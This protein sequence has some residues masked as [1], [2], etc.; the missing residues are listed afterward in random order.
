MPFLSVNGITVPVLLNT[1]GTETLDVGEAGNSYAGNVG[2][3]REA[4][5]RRT[6]VTLKHSHFETAKAF[7]DLIQGLGHHWSFDTDGYGSAGIGVADSDGFS[8]GGT[9]GNLLVRSREYDNASWTKVASSI[10]ANAARGPDGDTVADK[11]VEST[12]NNIHSV[13]QDVTGMDSRLA[14]NISFRVKPAERTRL[15][16]MLFD[17]AGGAGN[18]LQAAFNLTTGEITNLN[19]GAA[20]GATGTITELDDGWYRCSLAGIP[21]PGGAAGTSLSA[22]LRLGNASGANTYV[23]DGTSGMYLG[24]SQLTVGTELKPYVTTTSLAVAADLPAPKHGAARAEIEFYSTWE[25]VYTDGWTVAFWR[26][27]QAETAWNHYII[28]SDGAQWVDGVRNDAADTS[29]FGVIGDELIFTNTLE[30]A[31]PA[32]WAATTA[33]AVS[34]GVSGYAIP[35]VANGR[36]Y[37]VTTAGTSGAGEPTWPTTYGGTVVDGTVT[38]TDQGPLSGYFDD[39]VYMPFLILDEWAAE[40]YAEHSV[41]AWS[42]LPTV[43]ITG[44]G[45]RDGTLSV[46]V[47]GEVGQIKLI[48]A[49]VD[50]EHASN[51]HIQEFTFEEV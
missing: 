5:K 48:P 37:K 20:T 32:A 40:I 36:F 1:E 29:W 25:V 30:S 27:A 14:H 39:L 33:Y 50:N 3:A 45:V 31:H 28:R 12:A 16:M 51:V 49:T 18:Y 46:D 7:S 23:G 17:L 15:T 42:D 43:R 10:V 38:W 19:G 2:V 47:Q 9:G 24:G 4:L 11:I 22:Q 41:R 35:T 6:R 26:R 21:N 13:R 44:D 34:S 8:V